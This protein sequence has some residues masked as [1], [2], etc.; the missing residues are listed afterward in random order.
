MLLTSK[1]HKETETSECQ[2]SQDIPGIPTPPHPIAWHRESA[3]AHI[4]CAELAAIR[5]LDHP[6]VLVCLGAQRVVQAPDG[7]TSV[8]LRE[9]VAAE[10]YPAPLN[11]PDLATLPP[12]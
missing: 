3:L 4:P 9:G 8:A 10:P 6:E 12:N 7:I 1:N 2:C 5:K 11:D